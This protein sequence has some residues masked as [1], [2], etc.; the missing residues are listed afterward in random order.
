MC[1]RH[2]RRRR[3]RR[4]PAKVQDREA[5]R[6]PR[7]RRTLAHVGSTSARPASSDRRS[8]RP[9]AC[10][11]R[12]ARRHLRLRRHKRPPKRRQLH[13][14]GNSTKIPSPRMDPAERPT[15][16]GRRGKEGS[17][18]G[19]KKEPNAQVLCRKNLDFFPDDRQTPARREARNHRSEDAKMLG[20]PPCGPQ[21]T[22]RADQRDARGDANRDRSTQNHRRPVLLCAT[23]RPRSTNNETTT[24]TRHRELR[25]PRP[26]HLTVDLGD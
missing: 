19:I 5:S 25:D 21:R 9:L 4:P 7:R 22:G 23:Q 11:L 18:G 6:R 16:P 13:S 1:R 12:P 15:D 20:P 8:R 17:K 26:T 2:R 3:G 10:K 14:R 24:T